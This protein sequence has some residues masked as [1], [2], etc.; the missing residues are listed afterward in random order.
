MEVKFSLSK[1]LLIGFG[2]VIG[3]F[4]ISSSITY[5]IL[6]RNDA[7]N[8][9]LT[10]QIMPSVNLLTELQNMVTESKFLIK[11]WVHIDYHSDT[12]DKL[13]LRELHSTL[14]PEVVNMLRPYT[15]NWSIEDKDL[16]MQVDSIIINDIFKDHQH[17]MSLLD[18]FES[19][20]D[21]VILMEVEGLVDV[22]GRV[23]TLTDNAVE[24]IGTLINS[25]QEEAGGAYADIEA[26]TSFFRIFIVIGGLLVV[27]IGFL[28]SYYITSRIRRSIGIASEAISKLSDG[29][30]DADYEI[31]SNDEI[32]KLLFDLREMIKRLKMIVHSI[33]N[34][35]N[36]ISVA[37]EELNNV[38]MEISEG[39][40][41]QAS[42]A[43]EVTSSM[44][45]MGANI[46]Q[47][48]ENSNN[49]SKI[50]EKMA[51]DIEKIGTESEKSMV[52]I[53]KISEKIN[54]VNDI[55]FQTNLL[56][57]NAAV[58]AAR[59]GEHGKGFAVVATEVRKLA[60]HSKIAA[61]EILSL[62]KESVAN[63][64]SS[65]GLI[66]E[67]I[68]GIKK[69]SL[70]I[71]E[72]TAASMEQSSGADQVNNAVQQLNNITQQNAVNADGL[73]SRSQRLSNEAENLKNNISFFRM[74]NGLEQK[75]GVHSS[76][77]SDNIPVAS[78]TVVA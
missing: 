4:I 15:E 6:S 71:Q 48:T 25:Q 40:S 18:S 47:N 60:E 70:L 5:V 12:P 14:Y 27:L 2:L 8:S 32:A 10:G 69:T 19:Y 56:A 51:T 24:M 73:V 66:R 53:L 26:S 34:V 17:I 44:E 16:F 30:L 74:Q 33:I 22:D 50:S 11:N 21:F 37:S 77:E 63:T 52:S 29:D 1:K 54:I 23:I 35:S 55:A 65:A 13:R 45:E 46:Q 61:D 31:T 7:N 67:I 59:A 76:T 42:S 43:E 62:S 20:D 68:P 72:I 57:L 58:E 36:E 38:A 64:E 28:I 49:T 41:S 39:S 78:E 75:G 9:R 3:L